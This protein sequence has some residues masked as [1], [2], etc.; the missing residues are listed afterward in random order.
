MKQSKGFRQCKV[1][2]LNHYG[3]TEANFEDWIRQCFLLI[4]VN[5]GILDFRLKWR[6]PYCPSSTNSDFMVQMRSMRTVMSMLVRATR[7]GHPMCQSRACCKDII[8]G[9]LQLITE[10]KLMKLLWCSLLSKSDWIDQ[11]SPAFPDH[12]DQ[13]G[14]V[15]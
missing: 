5:E 11:Y 1:S 14:P 15:C 8:E 7:D 6:G 13:Y 3:S 4:F 10:K 2:S 9:R 12:I